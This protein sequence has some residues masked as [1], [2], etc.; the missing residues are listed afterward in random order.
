MSF[1]PI[2]KEHVSYLCA[3]L[4]TEIM[5]KLE[6][7]GHFVLRR[8]CVDMGCMRLAIVSMLQYSAAEKSFFFFDTGMY[9][10]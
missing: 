3:V 2:L 7:T 10:L 5:V 4:E 9:K 8:I 6:D 1:V